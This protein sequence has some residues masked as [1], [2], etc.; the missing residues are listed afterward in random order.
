MILAA[1]FSE[2]H[3]ATRNACVFAIKSDTV[4]YRAVNFYIG[5]GV[6]WR[7]VTGVRRP[8]RHTMSIGYARNIYVNYA[9]N[10]NERASVIGNSFPNWL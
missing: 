10:I 4:G 5:L 3:I 7:Q 6:Y 1:N 2:M 8:S 9:G